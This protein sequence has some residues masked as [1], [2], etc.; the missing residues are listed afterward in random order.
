MPESDAGHGC[1]KNKC[2][3]VWY[4]ICMGKASSSTPMFLPIY[5]FLVSQ[6]V[7]LLSPAQSSVP[8][9][10]RVVQGELFPVSLFSK[11]K[12]GKCYRSRLMCSV[13]QKKGQYSIHKCLI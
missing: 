5:P 9:E 11:T 8:R 13:I 3:G 4:E 1:R 7:P 10:E 2:Q 12:C 6:A